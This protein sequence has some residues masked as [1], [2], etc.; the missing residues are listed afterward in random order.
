MARHAAVDLSALSTILSF[1]YISHS[2]GRHSL[3][4]R[5]RLSSL[6]VLF[7]S[8]CIC[9]A[10]SAL[11][12]LAPAA[13]G[14][15]SKL[16]VQGQDETAPS[17]DHDGYFPQGSRAHLPGR[18]RKWSLPALIVLMAVR[19]EIFHR[20]NYQQ[21]CS[22][23][24][25]E[26]FLCLLLVGHQI[27][28]TRRKWE[29]SPSKDPDDP[30]RSVLDDIYD[31]FSG[32]RVVIF[33][34]V[35]SALAFSLGSFLSLSQA[36]R[37]GYLCLHLIDSRFITGLLQLV[38]LG[39]DASILILTWRLLAWTRT[40]RECTRLLGTAL[41]L[42][43][44]SVSLLYLGNSAFRGLHRVNVSFGSLHG[45]D[46]ATD[47]LAFAT[48]L[49][50]LSFWI[51][52]SSLITPFGVLT[53]LVGMRASCA[54][55]FHKGDW[56]HLARFSALAPL[57]LNVS[58]IIPF[59]YLYEIR[60]VVF[61]RRIVFAIL[62]L[63][64]LLVATI[65]TLLREPQAFGRH[66]LS[67][68][69]Y[70]ARVQH[71]RWL[72]V[73]STSQSLAAA[74]DIYQE[75]H[76]GRR[77]PPNFGEWY[78]YAQGSAVID[79]F[80]QIDRDLAPY[81]DVAP[82]TL[83]RRAEEMAATAG[84]GAITIR[85]GS[86]TSKDT[87][88]EEGNRDLAELV[89]MITKFS[90]HLPDMVLPI[91]LS[92]TPRILPTW[93]D[94]SPR[95]K[96]AATSSIAELLS[97]R[98]TREHRYSYNGAEVSGLF[99]VNRERRS[100]A[101]DSIKVARGPIWASD[102][103]Q[104][105]VEACSPLSRTRTRPH[106]N[107]MDFCSACIEAHSL[108]QLVTKWHQ[109]LDVCSQPDLRLLHGLSLTDPASA[110]IRQLRP[111]FGAS[112][113]DEFRD[114]VMPI[115][116]AGLERPE[117]DGGRPFA[118]R[119]DGLV[120]KGGS[121]GERGITNQAL[122]G[123]HT[124]R[125]LHLANT[126]YPHDEVTMMLPTPG[127]ADLL[128]YEKL[129]AS[130]A[131]GLVKLCV[132]IGSSDGCLGSNCALVR[133]AYGEGDGGMTEPLEH[134]YVLLLDEDDGPPRD[135]MRTLRS[136]SVP[137]VS[138]IFR[139]WFTDRLMPWLHFVPIDPRY[140][141]LHTTLAYFTG[142]EDRWGVHGRNVSMAG[143]AQDAEW[144]AQQGRRWAERALGERDM[145]IYMFRLLLEWG[146]MIDDLRNDI[147]FRRDENGE[148]QSVGWTR[149]QARGDGKNTEEGEEP[150]GGRRSGPGLKGSLQ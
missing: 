146:R 66:P 61:V 134:R 82:S 129:R 15:F 126:P 79:D 8:G 26:S 55:I 35:L 49:M 50:S 99:P 60:S 12:A 4:E 142:T 119:L 124:F 85:G 102:F 86:V 77:P 80:P 5:P 98:A 33:N 143:N 2:L 54:E 25:I 75:R 137:F 149:Q 130:E 93:E 28:V 14:R 139:T 19:L 41:C 108:G 63:V 71:D 51:C 127:N 62:L 64:L 65:L 136:N 21:Q 135:M 112:K 27:F 148:F 87:G 100:G 13:D 30:W 131:N 69:I 115:P 101:D 47:S 36:P 90:N 104:M 18:P 40:T 42:S 88:S 56:L 114:I 117:D 138:S 32:P 76:E 67:D 89:K 133:E 121:V 46:V 38:G 22:T 58:G 118:S 109:S 128:G 91:N 81:W 116:R 39:L 37:S 29:Y 110:P 45:F 31:W 48:L 7:F 107:F 1:I 72:S 150:G 113:T 43:A 106:W 53:F 10:V 6:L 140:H 123:S 144:I 57:W 73:A 145:E 103:R 34:S 105:Q 20:V 120:W 59:T 44:L 78:R 95:S 92:P 125:L 9:F 74:V 11:A 141:G 84:I 24:G 3:T 97:R 16:A 96:S 132:G 17:A 94:A 83:R 52:E 70:A 23:P 147:G 111:L 68:A 122:R